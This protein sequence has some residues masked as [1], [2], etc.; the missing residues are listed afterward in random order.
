M[1]PLNDLCRNYTSNSTLIKILIN[2]GADINDSFSQRIGLVKPVMSPLET[3]LYYNDNLSL[4]SLQEFIEYGVDLTQCAP[5]VIL[6]SKDDIDYEKIDYLLSKGANI[7]Q[8]DKITGKT[9]LETL[10][11]KK[12]INDN[13]IK[14]LISKG[15]IYKIP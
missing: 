3:L 15:A 12:V 1:N 9:A 8:I 10:H 5:L 11:S 6:C 13:A 7:N 14:Y 4:E 2:N